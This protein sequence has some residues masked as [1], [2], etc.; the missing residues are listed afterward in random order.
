MLDSEASLAETWQPPMGGGQRTAL[1][2]LCEAPAEV[3]RV[4]HEL[5]GRGGSGVTPPF[6]AFWGQRYATIADPDGNRLDLFA[7]QERPND[8]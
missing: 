6:D 2:F 4:Y 3:D 7:W 8:G 1:A 5:L